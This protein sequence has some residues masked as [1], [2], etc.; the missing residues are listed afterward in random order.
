M[1][2]H[3]VTKEE[4]EMLS[5]A[6][7]SEGAVPERQ[8]RAFD[9]AH[10]DKLSKANLRAL[11]L[12]FASVE[13]S[14]T[15][16]LADTLRTE[17]VVQGNPFEQAV[18]GTYAESVA[19]TSLV[20]E[21][22]LNPLPGRTIIDLPLAL[23]L[24][25]VDRLAG[26]KGELQG[27]PR[28]LTQIE[29]SIMAGFVGR[30]AADLATAFGP[31]AKLEAGDPEVHSS[32]AELELKQQAPV[33][34]LATA[35]D[36][37]SVKQSVN[38]A[39][40]VNSLDPILEDLIPQRWR[41]K[42]EGPREA[43]PASI[44]GLLREVEIPASVRLG[45]AGVS[46]QEVLSMEVGDVVRLENTV[47]DTIQIEIGGQLRFQAKPGLAGKKLAVQIVDQA[48]DSAHEEIPAAKAA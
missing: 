7:S 30:L 31:V 20:F 11:E 34:V 37:L 2:K 8:V 6:L 9:F 36:A 13:K 1:S 4:N 46:M 24:P 26:G 39:L 22:A 25:I 40:P 18:F 10:P 19:E 33:I 21:V 43:M 14:W 47:N 5:E 35:W 12:V 45:R 44:A 3:T 42:D 41:K 27:E 16:T 23:A 17:A 38:V 15:G 28:P 32:P 29:R 48:E